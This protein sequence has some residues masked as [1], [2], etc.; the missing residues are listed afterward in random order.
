MGTQVS[1]GRGGLA[2]RLESRDTV[3]RLPSADPAGDLHDQRDREHL[4]ATAQDHQEPRSL[5]QRRRG[6]ET[7]L[8]G[9]EEHHSRLG[10]PVQ[11]LERS[12]EPICEPLRRSL[13]EGSRLRCGADLPTASCV[14]RKRRPPAWT[15]LNSPHTKIRTSPR[16]LSEP[17]VSAQNND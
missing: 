5:P 12:H 10:P 3:L 14:R 7:D 13:Y 6:H 16:N 8:A 17:D 2:A 9:V 1:H 15:S 4:R 11:G